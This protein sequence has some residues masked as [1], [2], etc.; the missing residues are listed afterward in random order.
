[1]ASLQQPEPFKQ[2]SSAVDTL[3]ER[4]E[5]LQQ[6]LASLSKTVF[7]ISLIA[8]DQALKI[9]ILGRET[10]YNLRFYL[11]SLKN[12]TTAMSQTD[13]EN[14]KEQADIA[15]D[16][17]NVGLKDEVQVDDMFKAL[18]TVV[19]VL[20][21]K[22]EDKKDQRSADVDKV[23]EKAT[24]GANNILKDITLRLLGYI[25]DE[26][27]KALDDSQLFVNADALDKEVKK[28]RVAIEAA[29]SSYN[30]NISALDNIINTM[31]RLSK[32]DKRDETF[33]KSLKK[34]A[35]ALDKTCE[36][37]LAIVRA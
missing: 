8:K 15:R 23:I 14:C 20:H 5:G 37:K 1:M 18:Q 30:E 9:N 6:S 7:N 33:I 31:D 28:V 10:R 25:K 16:T 27:R 11:E 12:M 35:E 13:F 3:F 32:E 21:K 24:Q 22:E 34:N 26:I 17:M 4:Y 19:D 2:L 36:E 29:K